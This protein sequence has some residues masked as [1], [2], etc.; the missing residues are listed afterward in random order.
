MIKAIKIHKKMIIVLI[1]FV[2]LFAY[3]N[4][5]L[6]MYNLPIGEYISKID[7]PN[8]EYTLKAYRYSGGATVDWSIRVE[9]VNN[10]SGKIR[11]IY[12]KYHSQEAI[13][14]WIDDENVIINGVKLNIEKDYYYMN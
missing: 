7:S 6:V 2:E 13:M 11:N 1:I 9:L 10:K 4:S 3:C 5:R 12:Y 14:E 8:Y